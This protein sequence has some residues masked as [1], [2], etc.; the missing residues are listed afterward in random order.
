ME[1]LVMNVKEMAAMLGI[2]APKAYDMTHI[3]GFPVL[4]VGKRRLVPID[5]FKK[6]LEK[7]TEG[8]PIDL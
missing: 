3:E 4:M 6:W 2:S 5:A 7:Q 8:K 1:K